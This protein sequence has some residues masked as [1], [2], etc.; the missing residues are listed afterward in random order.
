M[1]Y[2]CIAEKLGHSFSKEIHSYLADYPYEL[3]EIAPDKLGEFMRAKDFLAINVTIP[4][5]QDVIPY[6][7]E[8]SET[9]KSIGA[10]NT[11]VNKNGRLYGYNTDFF[12][13]KTLMLTNGISPSGKKALVLGSGGTSKTAVAVLEDMGAVEIIKVSRTARDGAVTYEDAYAKHSDAELIVNTT[14]VGMY[15]NIG[16]APV[17]IDRFPRLEAVVDAVYNP[18]RSRLVSDALE[19]GVKAV[20]GLYMLVA[21]AARACELFIDTEISAEKISRVFQIMYKRTENVVLIGMPASGKS[22]V[23]KLVAEKLGMS[24][25]DSDEEIVRMTGKAIPDIFAESGEAEFRKIEAEAI[26]K[27]SAEKNTVI[28]TGGGAILNPE[29]VRLLRENGRIYFLDRPLEW[30]IPTDDRPTASS[31]EA[32]EKRYEERY[33]IYSSVCDVRVKTLETAEENAEWIK[34]DF[35]K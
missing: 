35:L 4:Y 23:G 33:P 7:D 31:R 29:S 1:K 26:K 5:K 25:K 21:Q 13:M 10:V 2:G 24:F 19:K 16:V 28:A 8:I 15:P 6:L 14:P 9:A 32:L 22:T 17:E 27:L 11:V 20:G 30:I 12:G 18:L 34:E 3:C